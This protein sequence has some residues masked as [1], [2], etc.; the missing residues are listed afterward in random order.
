MTD[1][2]HDIVIIFLLLRHATKTRLSNAW[3]TLI[4]LTSYD[5]VTT[6]A[7]PFEFRPILAHEQ[8]RASRFI[9]HHSKFHFHYCFINTKLS[10][11]IINYFKVS[12]LQYAI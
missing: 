6:H 3:T 2:L 11:P 5:H 7:L 8:W 4:G 1:S 9:S 12:V 10:I